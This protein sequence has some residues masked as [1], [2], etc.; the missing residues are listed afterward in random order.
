[1]QQPKVCNEL[2]SS[3]IENAVNALVSPDEPKV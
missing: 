3:N 2:F 1:M